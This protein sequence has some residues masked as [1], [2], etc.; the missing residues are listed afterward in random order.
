MGN[1]AVSGKRRAAAGDFGEFR[2]GAGWQG[3]DSGRE[4]V[5]TMFGNGF[6]TVFNGFDGERDKNVNFTLLNGAV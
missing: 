1:P 2:G 4:S 3:V 5:G 6:A